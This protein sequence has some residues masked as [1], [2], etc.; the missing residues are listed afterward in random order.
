MNRPTFKV[1]AGTLGRVYIEW[2]PELSESVRWIVQ[3][4]IRS[5]LDE[6]VKGVTPLDERALR[7]VEE[8]LS[9]TF[10]RLVHTG[11]IAQRLGAWRPA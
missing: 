7:L 9:D 4:E 10:D 2:P 5:F 6:L 3:N 1:T 8:V 11:R